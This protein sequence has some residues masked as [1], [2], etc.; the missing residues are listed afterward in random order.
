MLAKTMALAIFVLCLLVTTPAQ[1][2][3]ISSITD[4]E[5]KKAIEQAVKAY[6]KALMDL[7]KL[8]EPEAVLRLHTKEFTGINDGQGYDLNEVRDNLSRILQ[9][10]QAG[11][12]V[13]VTVKSKNMTIELSGDTAWAKFDSTLWVRVN[14]K[15][16]QESNQRMSEKFKQ[17]G[18]QW[19]LDHAISSTIEHE[20][21]E[22][23]AERPAIQLDTIPV[24]RTERIVNGN[25]NVS[26]GQFRLFS[27]RLENG[28]VV[29]GRFDVVGGRWSDIWVL[30][31]PARDYD[32]WRNNRPFRYSYLS[33]KVVSGSINVYLPTG[34]YC[35]IFSNLHSAVASAPMYAVIDVK[36][37]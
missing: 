4:E 26:A 21:V 12:K 30:L 32:N 10:A 11:S 22:V 27:I 2:L 23:P 25:F 19:L 18:S 34:D 6:G 15:L 7:P 8:R 24:D 33:G 36:R 14:G 17:Y 9:V 5:N 37:N 20:E 3:N 1:T 35:L 29:S 28:G 13:E 16:I 31:I